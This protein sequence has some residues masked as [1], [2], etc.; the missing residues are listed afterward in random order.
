MHPGFRVSST[1][2]DIGVLYPFAV[3]GDYII[4]IQTLVLYLS[5]GLDIFSI[6]CVTSRSKNDCDLCTGS[7]ILRSNERSGGVVDQ[8][9]K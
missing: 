8:P 6:R 7:H 4:S 2:L 5:D 3:D 9:I 1:F